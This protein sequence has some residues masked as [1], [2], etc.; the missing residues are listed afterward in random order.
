MIVAGAMA[1]L[2]VTAARAE[3]IELND[4]S[5]IFGDVVS[6]QNALVVVRTAEGAE[7]RL[8]RH[9]IRQLSAWTAERTPPANGA[10]PTEAGKLTFAGSETIGEALLPA[11]LEGYLAAAGSSPSQWAPDRQAPDKTLSVTK[12]SDGLPSTVRI[13]ARESTA[14]FPALRSGD[15][16]V[17]MASRPIRQ[18]ELIQSAMLGDLSA[19]EN[20]RVI[21]LDGVAIIVHPSNPLRD[22]DRGEIAGILSGSISDWSAIG[23]KSG[24]IRV[25]TPSQG[26]GTYAT[27]LSLVP[28]LPAIAPAATPGFESGDALS[29]AVANDPAGVGFVGLANIRRAKAL[30]IRECGLTYAP[31]SFTVKTDEYPLAR[32]LFLYTP[33]A[34]SPYAMGFLRYLSSQEAQEV[35]TKAGFVDLAVETDRDNTQ[36]ARRLALVEQV[37]VKMRRA[38]DFLKITAQATRLSVTLRFHP[39]SSAL[40]SRAV[41]DL[42]RLAVFAKA[43]EVQARRLIVLGFS[44]ASGDGPPNMGLAEVRA[45]KV[46]RLLRQAGVAVSLAKGFDTLAPVACDNGADSGKNRR[47]EIWLQ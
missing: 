20:Q 10:P 19:P 30:S 44:S 8:P 47:V 46:A 40:D 11:L 41:S 13:V 25:Y 42:G 34:I 21:A 27:L 38:G 17:A 39:A 5:A 22:L 37:P 33:G 23:G 18:D 14:G 28:A 29:D 26:T 6:Q 45:A 1:G 43:P 15:A 4:N 16:D 32:R 36:L 12:P 9:Q 31:T 24:P 35:T 7:F 3:R 2:A